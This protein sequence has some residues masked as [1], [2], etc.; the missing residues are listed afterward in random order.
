MTFDIIVIGK[1]LVGSAV[2][3]YLRCESVKVALIGPDEPGKL[4][5]AEVN[6]N[7]EILPALKSLW[8]M[9]IS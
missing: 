4:R 2:A 9:L 3:K 5:N 7:R 6:S 1:G 8:K